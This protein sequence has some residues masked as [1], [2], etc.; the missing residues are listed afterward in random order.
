MFGRLTLDLTRLRTRF[1]FLLV[2]P[3]YE[4]ERMPGAARTGRGVQFRY[5]TA[6]L[7][8][9]QDGDGVTATSRRRGRRGT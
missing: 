8:L 4:M 9:H 2:T 1:P 7:T 5:A 6:L 3:Q